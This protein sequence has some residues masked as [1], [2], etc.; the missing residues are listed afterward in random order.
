MTSCEPFSY[1]QLVV[2]PKL[3][4]ENVPTAEDIA[5]SLS[6]TLQRPTNGVQCSGHIPLDMYT[7]A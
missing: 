7:C 5:V 6:L 2:A 1:P 3:Y 4:C